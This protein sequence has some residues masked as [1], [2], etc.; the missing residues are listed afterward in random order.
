MSAGWS[1][2]RRRARPLWGARWSQQ[3]RAGQ[4]PRC[5]RRRTRNWGGSG[6]L[7]IIALRQPP[8]G[9]RALIKGP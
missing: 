2:S 9:G 3:G 6:C 1:Q 4:L 7:P 5:G 8:N